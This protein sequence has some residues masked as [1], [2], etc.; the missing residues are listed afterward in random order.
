MLTHF[1]CFPN[2][3]RLPTNYKE[4]DVF[5]YIYIDGSKASTTVNNSKSVEVFTFLDD[6][7]PFFQLST[8]YSAAGGPPIR[9]PTGHVVIFPSEYAT[10]RD[11][12]H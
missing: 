7:G 12:F 6:K 3:W 10:L 8:L 4:S 2:G 9:S 1:V 5:V 11:D